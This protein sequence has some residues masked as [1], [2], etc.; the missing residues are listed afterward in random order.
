M[1]CRSVHPQPTNTHFSRQQQPHPGGIRTSTQG[2]RIHIGLLVKTHAS[3][4][5]HLRAITASQ[6]VHGCTEV[7]TSTN[8][9]EAGGLRT[10]HLLTKGQRVRQRVEHSGI[11][12][13]QPTGLFTKEEFIQRTRH[14]VE[15]Y[16]HHRGNCATTTTSLK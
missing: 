10:C 11:A 9:N 1:S 14:R 3:S 15:Y 12:Q 13:G 16:N 2:Y 5:H 8:I 6:A 4:I 7:P